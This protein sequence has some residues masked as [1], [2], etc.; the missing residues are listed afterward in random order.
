MSGSLPAG[1]GGFGREA[2]A[3][4][5]GRFPS[6]R[7]A[8]LGDFFLDKYLEV[9]P[10]LAEI[11]LETGKTAH[12]VTATRHSPGAAGTVVCNLAALGAGSLRAIGFSGDDGEGYEL[13]ADLAGL[14]CDASSLHLDLGRRTPTYLKPR[15]R[16]DPSLEGEHSR[17]D[18]KNRLPAPRELEDRILASLG[19]VLPELDALIVLDQ[20]EEP[21][22]GTLTRRIVEALPGL[23]APHPR[24]VA[25][26]DSRRRIMDFRGLILKMNQFELTGARAAGAGASLPEAEIAGALPGA[27]A[28][29]G[30]PIFVTAGERGVW[31]IAANSGGAAVRVPAVRVA[32]P[33][34]PTGAGDSFTA[35]S[36]LAL[37]AGASLEEA[38][39]VGNLVASVTV[40]QLA[41]TGTARPDE[42]YAA[43]DAWLEENA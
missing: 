21:G 19:E 17:Y 9:D 41:T 38:A 32:G 30:K 27:A 14:G 28:R 7:V 24:I 15:D 22:L 33:V 35:G 31:T 4:L 5:L 42:L 39:L 23:L 43:L 6:I 36:V 20:V 16:G 13:R 10:A 26:A 11:S 1:L 8:V 29:S 12:Q 40:R 3:R 34:D 18:L 25:Y 2:L 37:A